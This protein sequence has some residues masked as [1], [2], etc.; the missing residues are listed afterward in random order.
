ML[1]LSISNR[2]LVALRFVAFKIFLSIL[3]SACRAFIAA[4]VAAAAAAVVVDNVV[5]VVAAVETAAAAAGSPGRLGNIVIDLRK[6]RT[7]YSLFCN[8]S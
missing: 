7:L 3:G 4:A 8:S 2:G 5:V 6:V 1:F